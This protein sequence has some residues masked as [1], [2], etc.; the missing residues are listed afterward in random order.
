MV[1][2]FSPLDYGV[3]IAM[4]IISASIGLYFAF[5][6]RDK[7]KVSQ[8]LLGD[9]KLKIFPVAMSIM[10]SF[11]SAVS[12]LGFSQ[13]MYLF[14]TM[15]VIIGASYFITQPF[16]AHTYV[17]FFHKL[18]ITSA[19]E[20]L[21]RRFDNKV[22]IVASLIFV[23]E[24]FAYMA[25]VLYSP[26]LAIG[27][28][29]G[30]SLWVSIFLTGLICSI[31]TSLGGMKAVVFTDTFQ[32]FV[33]F[34]GLIAI[35]VEGTRQIGSF[36]DIYD[37]ADRTERIEFFDFDPSPFKRHTFWSITIG[38]FFTSLTVYGSNQ[39]TIQ[40]YI[41]VPSVKSAQLAMYVNMIATVAIL[42]VC[43]MCGLVAFGY[44]FGC[45]PKLMGEI[46]KYDQ[47]LPYLVVDLLKDFYGVPGLF[48][49]CVYSAALSTVSSGLNSLTAVFLHDFIYPLNSHLN[50]K[51]I[52]EKQAIFISRVLASIFGLITIGLAF[53]C[54]Y[55]GQTV[56]QVS[57]SIFGLL[58]GPLLGV[59]SLGMFVPCANA[60]G[61]LVG[62][63]VSLVVNCY[64]G[65][66]SILYGEKPKIKILSTDKCPI[67]SNF[68]STIF[69]SNSM[70]STSDLTDVIITKNSGF[71]RVY[72]ISYYWY[73]LIAIVIVFTLG[74]LVSLITRKYNKKELDEELIFYSNRKMKHNN[75]NQSVNDMKSES[76]LLAKI[77]S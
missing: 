5:K 6:E 36:S 35:I 65:I 34:G 17:P 40:R 37:L 44:Y 24:M 61:A 69:P 22:R 11:T 28:V 8:V 25:V 57:L 3:F 68:N 53:L 46:T 19:Y 1:E 51:K 27:Q 71:S 74:I 70:N 56:L 32:V 9:R 15:Y 14:G 75:R 20:Y 31:Y 4:L 7:K 41:S 16:A 49:A 66:G 54:Q 18:K 58:G 72:D 52:T 67:V 42:L 59:I 2:K 48:I 10:A 55:V 50:W 21:E 47:I 23:V 62:L 60:T 33:M 39:A 38:G 73:S 29:T 13:E 26:A 77:E 43:C 45:D 30:I 12:I 64:I 76:F 63:I